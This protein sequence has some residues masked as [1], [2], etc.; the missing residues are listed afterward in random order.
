MSK[1]SITVQELGAMLKDG[2]SIDLI[3][4]RTPGEFQEIHV[5]VAKNVP[6]DR[7]LPEALGADRDTSRH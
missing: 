4:V 3:D 1:N 7:L 5:S 2:K 6:L